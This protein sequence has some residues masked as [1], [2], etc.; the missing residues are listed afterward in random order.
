MLHRKLHRNILRDSPAGIDKR[1]LKRELGKVV[2][3]KVVSKTRSTDLIGAFSF[4]DSPQGHTF[5]ANHVK[6]GA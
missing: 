1:R 3:S 5:W 2:R 6:W 4:V